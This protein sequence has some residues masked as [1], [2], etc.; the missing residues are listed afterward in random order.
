MAPNAKQV[1]DFKQI[2]PPS[3]LV[4]DKRKAEADDNNRALK[5]PRATKARLLIFKLG[6]QVEELGIGYYQFHGQGT[7]H[8]CSWLSAT[9]VY[10]GGT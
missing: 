3:I 10:Y 7:Y 5:L 4:S 6:S 9:S 2:P 8:L 1:S